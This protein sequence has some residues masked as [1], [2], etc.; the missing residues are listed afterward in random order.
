L[1]TAVAENTGP[2]SAG[3]AANYAAA[4]RCGV[5]EN[6]SEKSFLHYEK[7]RKSFRR[8]KDNSINSA[9]ASE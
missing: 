3:R 9:S 4:F 5:R 7:N 1:P 6:S 2:E 8:F